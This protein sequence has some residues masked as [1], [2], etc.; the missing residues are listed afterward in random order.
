MAVR[1]SAAPQK[2]WLGNPENVGAAQQAFTHRAHM[3]SLAG[4]GEWNVD[5][6]SKG[7]A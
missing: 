3:N 4:I 2:A 5:L 6:E 1:Y 7:A